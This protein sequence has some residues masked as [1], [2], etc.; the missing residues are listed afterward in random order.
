MMIQVHLDLFIYILALAAKS[1]RKPTSSF[2]AHLFCFRNI[3]SSSEINFHWS[4][5]EQSSKFGILHFKLLILKGG[6]Q[7]CW[8]QFDKFCD[9]QYFCLDSGEKYVCQP[10]PTVSFRGASGQEYFFSEV[11]GHKCD[12]LKMETNFFG[13]HN[14]LMTSLPYLWPHAARKTPATNRTISP[15]PTALSATK[16]QH[17]TEEHLSYKTHATK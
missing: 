2:S 12:K 13:V 6:T 17:N 16:I 7:P 14:Q 15:T 5:L 9:T 1:P 11:Q 10:P 4:N 8:I 3:V